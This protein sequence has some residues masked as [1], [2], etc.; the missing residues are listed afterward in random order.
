MN[1]NTELDLIKKT[2]V[3]ARLAEKCGTTKERFYN[4]VKS[5]CKLEKANNDQFEAFLMI[6]EKYDLNPIM[7]QMWAYPSNNGIMA[8]VSIDGWITIVNNHPQFDG[9]ETSVQLDDAGNPISATC[10]MY[11]KDR[12]PTTKTVYIREWKKETSPVWKTMPIHFLEMRAYIQCARMTFNISGIHDG[13]VTPIIEDTLDITN[14]I[15]TQKPKFTIINDELEKEEL[16][17]NKENTN[18]EVNTIIENDVLAFE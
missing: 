1:T 18:I 14:E 2:S 7:K 3:T 12:R 11:R 10:T 6:A 9:Y 5:T 8:M 4:V 16:K 17:E 15:I 13:D